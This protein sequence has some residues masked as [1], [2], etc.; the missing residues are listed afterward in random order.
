[1][2]STS[3]SSKE[4]IVLKTAYAYTYTYCLLKFIHLYYHSVSTF[5][6]LASLD[7]VVLVTR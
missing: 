4:R 3:L 6:A 5:S 7:V 1:M 2:L